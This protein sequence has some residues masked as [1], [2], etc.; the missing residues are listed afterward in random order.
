MTEGGPCSWEQQAWRPGHSPSPRPHGL[1]QEC[2]GLVRHSPPPGGLVALAMLTRPEW[3]AVPSRV[4]HLHAA[5]AH[6]PGWTSLLVTKEKRQSWPPEPQPENQRLG[7]KFRGSV[8]WKWPQ[9]GP[10]T[11]LFHS[12]QEEEELSVTRCKLRVG[13]CMSA[14]VCVHACTQVPEP[15]GMGS[16][17]SGREP[18]NSKETGH[19]SKPPSQRTL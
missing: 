13:A 10:G 8:C 3:E 4:S 5:T 1:K 14:C 9:R 18:T 2:A 15:W 6:L 12:K 16:Q 11:P 17:P 19:A 7:S